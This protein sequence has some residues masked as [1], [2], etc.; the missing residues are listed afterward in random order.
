[1]MEK[2]IKNVLSLFDGISCG[3]LA[4]KRAGI[5]FENYYASEIDDKCIMVSK[6]NF[7]DIFHLGDVEKL[8]LDSLPKFDL[9][10]AGS[11][12]QGIS[13]AANN[14]KLSDPRSKLFFNFVEIIK[15]LKPK[16]WF[17]ENVY[18]DIESLSIMSEELNCY[19]ISIN[20]NMVSAQNRDRLYWSNFN[21]TKPIDKNIYLE[22][23]LETK[24]Y[25]YPCAI[26][27][28][29]YNGKKQGVLEVRTVDC[30]KANCLTTV[31]KDSMLT[32][33][34]P[35]KY[36]D[37][38]KQKYRKFSRIEI[39]RLQTLPDDYFPDTISYTEI[40]KMSANCWTIDVIA[41]IFGCFPL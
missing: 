33:N 24:E 23:I 26:R 15:K 18:A 19:P 35:G 3:Y 29:N 12:C 25:L 11:P 4:L 20:S 21:F 14:D 10:I 9:I 38:Y 1:M 27:T 22:D 7:P 37:G 31:F 5:Q 41:H 8:D 32:I 36:E 28:R 16:F 34:K 40:L 2:K 13:L 17:L 39:C 30:N 6:S